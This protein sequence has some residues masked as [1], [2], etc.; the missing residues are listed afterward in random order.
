MDRYDWRVEHWGTKWDVADVA[1]IDAIEV[2]DE[3]GDEEGLAWFSF[4][5]WT[6]WGPPV[7]VWDALH[8][9]GIDV[10]ADYQDEGGWFEGAYQHGKNESWEPEAEEA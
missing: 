4:R 7:P 9:H 5:C 3:E 1:I 6:A 8:A 10:E 2:S